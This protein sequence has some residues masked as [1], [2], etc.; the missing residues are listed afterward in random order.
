MV[1]LT[2]TPSDTSSR[3][4]EYS[5]KPPRPQNS[6]I[7]YRQEH[8][9]NFSRNNPG[10]PQSDVSKLIAQ[11][12][13]NEKPEIRREWER[14]AEEEKLRHAL[15]YPGYRYSPTTKESKTKIKGAAKKE[16][17]ARRAKKSTPAGTN[18]D[19]TVTPAPPL[20]PSPS[21]MP[22]PH[23]FSGPTVIT[24]TPYFIPYAPDAEYTPPS[25]ASL[26]REGSTS[27]IASSEESP[28]SVESQ[29]SFPPLQSTCVPTDTSSQHPLANNT[30]PLLEFYPQN[31]QGMLNF[32]VAFD[33]SLSF[34]DPL[35]SFSGLSSDSLR[36]QLS[37]SNIDH[38][39]SQSNLQYTSLLAPPQGNFEVLV[40]S[41]TPGYGYNN[42]A[43]FNGV[44]FAE[45]QHQLPA[46]T[47]ATSHEVL[48]EMEAL[49][50][51]SNNLP[52]E[53]YNTIPPYQ[54]ADPQ[55]MMHFVDFDGAGA[56]AGDASCVIPHVAL[57]TSDPHLQNT[58]T[59][60]FSPMTNTST[61]PF[62]PYLPPSGAPNSYM[63][64]VGANW[65]TDVMTFTEHLLDSLD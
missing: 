47:E 29:A 23:P 7:L 64:R 25:T 24:R 35:Q 2:R 26:T 46:S 16:K 61:V 51:S 18:A 27:S 49:L 43:L 44:G 65:K 55:D 38:L 13:K 3:H 28:T 21:T 9:K 41:Q 10:V 15:K 1:G 22:S 36:A 37:Q 20:P 19:A 45:S 58:A 6:W 39:F 12:W 53:M 48:D 42:H 34:A 8:C 57:P 4:T 62:S 50:H 40:G 5:V 52:A 60:I 14:K 11:Q 31:A 56:S 59:A 54:T 32:N 33:E 63:R 17:K 30:L